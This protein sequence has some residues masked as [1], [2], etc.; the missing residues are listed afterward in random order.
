M[1]PR[2]ALE[3]VSFDDQTCVRL[4]TTLIVAK[5]S[6]T[7]RLP[8]A[9]TARPTVS[10]SASVDR[11]ST[12]HRDEYSSEEKQSMWYNRDEIVTM[13]RNAIMDANRPQPD[14]CLRG[15]EAKTREG[16][17]K[18]KQNRNEARV[19][20][21]LEQE[22]QDDDGLSDPNAIADA[23]FECSESC[24]ADAQMLALRDEKDAMEV[25]GLLKKSNH[26]ALPPSIRLIDMVCTWSAAA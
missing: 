22:I 24:V 13:R 12:S 1:A 17:R 3:F 11:R 20:V 2:N 16:A 7:T 6:L 21:F 25:Q 15:L 5:S 26:M 23:Y 14:T 4:S 10:F 9:T 19:A 18:K 8:Q